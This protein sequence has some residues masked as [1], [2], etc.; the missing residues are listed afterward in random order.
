VSSPTAVTKP[1]ADASGRPWFA[2]DGALRRAV[3]DPVA[4]LLLFSAML[5]ASAAL[6]AQTVTWL[7]LAGLAGHSLSGST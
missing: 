2:L 1:N 4:P 6:G 3:S 5:L 7:A